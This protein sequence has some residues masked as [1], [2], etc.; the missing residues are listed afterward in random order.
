MHYYWFTCSVNLS[1]GVCSMLYW[2]SHPIPYAWHNLGDIKLKFS[3]CYQLPTEAR[4]HIFRD[5]ELKFG[6]CSKL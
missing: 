1:S 2:C 5:I 3:I 4:I 6:I